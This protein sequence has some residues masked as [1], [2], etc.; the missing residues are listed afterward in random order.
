M[1]HLLAIPEHMTINFK[2][3]FKNENTP[4]YN[5]EHGIKVMGFILSVPINSLVAFISFNYLMGP[6]ITCV[7]KTL[8]LPIKVIDQPS[9]FAPWG[10]VG[11]R[12]NTILM[13]NNIVADGLL[14]LNKP[15]KDKTRDPSYTW[16]VVFHLLYASVVTVGLSSVIRWLNAAADPSEKEWGYGQIAAMAGILLVTLTQWV[17]YS[18]EESGN[19]REYTRVPRYIHWSR[20]CK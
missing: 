6:Y 13:L 20:L 11:G 14:V 12:T 17:Q 5:Y 9:L 1:Y 8:G 3:I 7:E 10:T 4:Y 18:T 19:S 16:A 15:D 2:G